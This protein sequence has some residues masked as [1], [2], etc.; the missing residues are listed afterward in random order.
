MGSSIVDGLFDFVK[1]SIRKNEFCNYCFK[2]LTIKWPQPDAEE[3]SKALDKIFNEIG[4]SL[5]KDDV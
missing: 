4:S 1:F 3:N 2:G 5:D